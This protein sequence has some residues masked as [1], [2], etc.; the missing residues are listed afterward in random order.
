MAEPFDEGVFDCRQT[1][2][3]LSIVSNTQ[4]YLDLFNLND[5]ARE[6]AEFLFKETLKRVTPGSLGERIKSARLA[7]KTEELQNGGNWGN[8]KRR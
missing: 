6:Q 7:R 4:L 8:S 2:K 5:R 3:G 1:K